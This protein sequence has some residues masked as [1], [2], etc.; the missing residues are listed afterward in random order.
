MNTDTQFADRREYPVSA[1]HTNDGWVSRGI[2]FEDY[3]RMNTQTHGAN[4]KPWV[5][6]FAYNDKQLQHV[7]LLRAY[8]YVTGCAYRYG[9]PQKIDRDFINKLAT[10]KALK[11]YDISPD[12][13]AIQHQMAEAHRKAVLRAGGYLELHAAIAWRAWRLGNPSTEVAESLGISPWN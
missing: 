11:G 7:L 10:K 4:P 12:A 1:H 13:P 8:R 6:P 5:P 3:F 2:A 9:M